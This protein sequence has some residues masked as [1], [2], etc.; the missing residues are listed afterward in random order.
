MN[1]A[2][3]FASYRPLM[4]GRG[5][6]HSES[7]RRVRVAKFGAASFSGVLA[8]LGLLAVVM[9]VNSGFGDLTDGQ[10]YVTAQ[11]SREVSMGGQR[12][13]VGR[14]RE[15]PF[16]LIARLRASA[17]VVP[18]NSGRV[19]AWPT[20]GTSTYQRAARMARQGDPEAQRFV[21]RLG[22]VNPFDAQ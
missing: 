20:H 17:R 16:L 21:S 8:V 2:E 18:S 9:V 19:F 6:R 12:S 10:S 3:R 7:L 4:V 22:D 5:G 15:R 13:D 11:V 14:A 1:D